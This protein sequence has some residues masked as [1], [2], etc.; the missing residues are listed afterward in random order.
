MYSLTTE[1]SWETIL[2]DFISLYFDSHFDWM[3]LQ[4]IGSSI[5]GI[6]VSEVWGALPLI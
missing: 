2:V 3:V 4:G 6:A 5:R 1:G